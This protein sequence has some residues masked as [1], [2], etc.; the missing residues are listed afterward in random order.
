MNREI[1]FTD[2]QMYS[3]FYNNFVYDNYEFDDFSYFN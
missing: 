3:L 1:T 2:K